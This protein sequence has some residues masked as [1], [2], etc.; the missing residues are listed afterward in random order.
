MKNIFW[1]TSIGL[2]IT[3]ILVLSGHHIYKKQQNNLTK[4][5]ETTF[6]NIVSIDLNRRYKET[7]APYYFGKHTT[8]PSDQVKI[9]HE[10]TTAYISKKKE[11][12]ESAILNKHVNVIQTFL[13]LENPIKVSI[14]DSLLFHEL[15]KEGISIPVAVRYTDNTAKKIYNSKSDTTFYAQANSMEE[16]VLG[17]RNEITLQ[18]FVKFPIFAIIKHA[19]VQYLLLSSIWFLIIGILFFL[20]FRKRSARQTIYYKHSKSEQQLVTLTK[21]SDS[22]FWDTEKRTLIYYENALQIPELSAKLFECF[23]NSPDHYLS[24]ETMEKT[25]R[26]KVLNAKSWRAQSIKRLRENL[27]SIPELSV[28]VIRGKGYQ[29]IIK[30]E[31]EA[32][33]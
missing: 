27:S 10:D 1:I 5:I 15:L 12:S 28:E 11:H 26:G 8:S 2:I 19:K 31:G 30:N 14:L 9:I 29:L 3:F 17:V 4:V 25:L 20:V 23:L 24:N 16:I 33:A 18:A 7:E 22:L 21:V 32:N 6:Q 13:Q